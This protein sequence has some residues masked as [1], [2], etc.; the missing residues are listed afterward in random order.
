MKKKIA[1][2][3][4]GTGQYVL[5]RGLKTHEVDI[6]AIV[7][8]SDDGG[9]TGKLREELGVHATGDVRQCI[10]ALSESSHLMR[11][12]MNYRFESGP[13]YGHSF[14][15]LFL[16]ALEKVT[17]SFEEAVEEVSD[18]LA[19]RGKVIPV[20]NDQVRL[21]MTLRS[22]KE[23]YG[24][25]QIYLSEEINQGYEKVYLD[26]K[27]TANPK[28][29]EAIL[30]ADVVVIGPGG[31]FTSIIANLLVDGIAEALHQ[32]KATKIF[33]VNLMNR[34]GQTLGYGVKEYVQ[35]LSHFLGGDIL[36][37]VLVNDQ[38]PP[39]YLVSLYDLEGE[40]VHQNFDNAR[41]FKAPMLG[42]LGSAPVSDL[43]PRSPIRH[44]SAALAAQIMKIAS[45]VPDRTALC[46]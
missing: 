30:E 15:N 4:G 28:A 12:L 3:G 9:S 25:K 1:T 36:D 44:D 18:I 21:G 27:A 42:S 40:F 39:P 46:L 17:G 24:E 31:F 2:I 8:M 38:V 23:L 41:V 14:G 43:M 19:I 10:I 32:T 5:L 26:P 11:S 7:S 33:V 6:S 22:G 34:R 13:L 37:Y 20:T 29:V 35:Q 16:S 45:L